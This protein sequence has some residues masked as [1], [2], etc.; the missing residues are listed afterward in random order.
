IAPIEGS[1]AEAAGIRPGD[2]IVAI[3]GKD[4][5]GIGVEKSVRKMRGEPGTKVEITIRRPSEGGKLYRVPLVRSEIH[6]PS[7]DYDVLPSGIAYLRIR[8]FQDKTHEELLDAIGK[9]KAKLG[10]KILGVVLD[11]RRNPGGLVDQAVDVADEFLDKGVI[12]SM[13]GQGG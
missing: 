8:Q 3:D 13:R 4:A 2:E 9:V 6:V 11:M 7:V 10:G 12:F 1:P 5:K